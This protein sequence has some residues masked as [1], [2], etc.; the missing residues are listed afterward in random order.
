MYLTKEE[1]AMFNGE[2]GEATELAI[3]VV[4]KVGEVLGATRLIDVA[5][6]HISGISYFNILDYG[7][8]FIEDLEHKGACFRT[9]TTANP[10]AAINADF[11]GKFFSNEVINKQMRVVNALKNM[12]AKAFTCAPY[13][14]RTPREGEHLAWAE[15]NAVLYANSVC[16]ARTNREGGPLSLMEAIIGKTYLSGVH[17]DENRIPE[18][19][20][21][22]ESLRNELE[23]AAAG[24]IIGKYFPT[25]IP[26]VKG[27]SYSYEYYLRGFLAAFGSSSNSPMVVLEGVTP[28]Y[29]RLLSRGEIS[30]SENIS[31][32]E[33]HE[34]IKEHIKNSCSN[35]LY[36]IGCPHLSRKEVHDIVSYVLSK[37][38]IDI[39]DREMWLITYSNIKLS[40]NLRRKLLKHG[41]KIYENIC[42][43]VTRLSMIGVSCVITDSVKALHYIPK[44]AGVPAFLLNR[45]S[46]IRAFTRGDPLVD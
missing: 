2:F 27:L 12:G 16:G 31:V 23:V 1:E 40:D 26:Y 24:F 36:I 17:L 30:K 34:F 38:R 18:V 14:I 11:N 46:M 45:E 21:T 4:V 33:V 25:S 35:A 10:Y 37:D 42:P 5:H 13:Y 3:K 41:I 15:S 22:V 29:K 8:R 7:I 43:V 32:A 9:F 28:N 20:V 44:L 39:H 6:A 19:S